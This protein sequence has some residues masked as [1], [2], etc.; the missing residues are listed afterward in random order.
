MSAAVPWSI[1]VGYVGLKLIVRVARWRTRR[2]VELAQAEPVKLPM[3]HLRVIEGG[4]QEPLQ[5]EY[6]ASEPELR[7]PMSLEERLRLFRE[8]DPHQ[9]YT[10]E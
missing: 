1:I 8:R 5:G 10:G 4:K 9:P 2:L 3:R 7:R 6:I